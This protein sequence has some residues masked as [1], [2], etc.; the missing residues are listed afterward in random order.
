MPQGV[1]EPQPPPSPERWICY[2]LSNIGR[3]RP[4]STRRS[5]S[6]ASAP[7]LPP[8]D[9]EP[10]QQLPLHPSAE[11]PDP[12]HP[13]LASSEAK[14]IRRFPG[15]RKSSARRRSSMERHRR[16]GTTPT[17][18]TRPAPPPP[19]EHH[20][21]A[22]TQTLPYVHAVRR[23]SP[24]LPLPEQPTEGEEPP[25]HRRRRW[26]DGGRPKIASLAL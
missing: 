23:A 7:D 1:D 6:G 2:A 24:I 4:P 17:A 12:P 8:A 20:W 19:P 9:H 22:T 10:L 16:R 26:I 13:D 14:E 3:G 15:S 21:P 25:P 18:K 11:R 5:S